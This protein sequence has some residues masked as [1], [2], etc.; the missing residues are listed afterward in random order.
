M[1]GKNYP[2]NPKTKPKSPPNYPGNWRLEVAPPAPAERDLFLNVLMPVDKD[3]SSIPAVTRLEAANMLGSL[4]QGERG[5]PD[6]VVWLARDKD[7]LDTTESLS[8]RLPGDEPARHLIADLPVNVD[9]EIRLDG[10]VVQAQGT[11]D[12]RTQTGMKKDLAPSCSL[13]FTTGAGG[14]IAITPVGR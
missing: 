13:W 9:Y 1:N 6:T 2:L 7:T 12:S 8:Y 14:T 11:Q 3:Q 10:K 5:E 4:I